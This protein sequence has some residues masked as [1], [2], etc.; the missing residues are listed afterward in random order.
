M[1]ILVSATI[2]RCVGVGQPKTHVRNLIP[3]FSILSC[4][5][6]CLCAFISGCGK[7]EVRL[8]VYKV[9]GK[10][11]QNGT[12]LANA[13]VVFHAK[14]KKEGFVAPRATTAADGSFE[15]TTYAKGDGAP[16]GDYQVTISLWVTDKPEIGATNHLPPELSLPESSGLKATVAASENALEPFKIP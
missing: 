12:G 14:E 8:P 13:S 2:M 11:V 7:S 3:R 5:V 10:V 4:V 1:K 6:V 16:V 9:S 15:L